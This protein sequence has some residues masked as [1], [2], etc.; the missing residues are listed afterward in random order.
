MLF[1]FHFCDFI[2]IFCFEV[3]LFTLCLASV[4]CFEKGIGVYLIVVVLSIPA[5][6]NTTCWN[7]VIYDQL[8]C[9]IS[10]SRLTQIQVFP[11]VGGGGSRRYNRILDVRRWSSQIQ[12][13]Y[14]TLFADESMIWEK[15]SGGVGSANV[16]LGISVLQLKREVLVLFSGHYCWKQNVDFL[17]KY[18]IVYEKHGFHLGVD[19]R[20][21]VCGQCFCTLRGKVQKRSL[22]ALSAFCLFQ[23]ILTNILWKTHPV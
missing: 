2:A 9:W 15:M 1:G 4:W 14:L 19:R 18:I 3:K 23:F 6:P 5:P 7:G 8:R 17:P 22:Y 11:E 10:C 20:Q 13:G 16:L 21:L 12:T